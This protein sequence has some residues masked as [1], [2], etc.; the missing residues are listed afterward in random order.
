MSA[1]NASVQKIEQAIIVDLYRRKAAGN[2]D[3]HQ[4]LLRSSVGSNCSD[5]FVNFY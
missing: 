1:E 4:Q 2:G 3:F 5:G